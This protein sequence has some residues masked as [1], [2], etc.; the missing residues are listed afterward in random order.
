MD[1]V[2]ELDPFALGYFVMLPFLIIG[3][4]FKCAIAKISFEKNNISQGFEALARSQCLLRSKV[5][6]E[7]MPLLS[8][9]KHY[10]LFVFTLISTI[11]QCNI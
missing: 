1:E 4:F 7:K 8:Q 6:L 9:V 3:A 10:L 11:C 2:R 5:S